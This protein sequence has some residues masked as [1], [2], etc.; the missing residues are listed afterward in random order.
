MRKPQRSTARS[1]EYDVNSTA[2]STRV[3]TTTVE[4]I[5]IRLILDNAPPLQYRI[6]KSV[7]IAELA[8]IIGAETGLTPPLRFRE[9]NR[10]MDSDSAQ[11]KDRTLQ[12]L[13]VRFGFQIVCE[14]LN[15]CSQIDTNAKLH[16]HAFAEPRQ[17][18]QYDSRT[19][20][21]AFL[22]QWFS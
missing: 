18:L 13:G 8:E 1:D 2:P 21:F 9:F 14:P 7:T 3:E 19:G 6:E 4:E 22:A 16:V 11:Y 15:H 20:C 10:V 17:P 12:E 5:D